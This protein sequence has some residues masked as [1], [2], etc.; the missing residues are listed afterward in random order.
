M[1][2]DVQLGLLGIYAMDMH[3]A[4]PGNLYPPVDPRL[5][6][7]GWTLRGYVVGQ[8]AWLR[9]RS[10]VTLFPEPSCYGLLAERTAEPG[11]FA[12][13]LRGTEGLLEWAEDGEFFPYP[14]PHPSAI[15]VEQGFYGVY[16]SLQ[17]VSVVQAAPGAI[18]VPQTLLGGLLRTVGSGSITVVGHS[19]GAAVATYLTLD[20]AGTKGLGHVAGRFFASPHPGDA[21][22]A[23][24]FDTTVAD[25][26]AYAYILDIV[27]HL[28]VGL[29]FCSL[30]KLRVL[31]P[32]TSQARIKFSVGCFHHLLS[33]LAELQYDLQSWE[34]DC[35]CVLGPTGR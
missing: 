12:V 2:S 22:F 8:D 14:Y 1:V 34:A 7:G 24:L 19:L 11:S 3:V 25:Y 33:Y 30:P 4:Y 31:T 9:S 6:A 21:A 26:Q 5:A 32:S 28:P 16:G 15:S 10:P 29:G 18:I 27:P 13:V 17:Y 20:L 23:H 35:G